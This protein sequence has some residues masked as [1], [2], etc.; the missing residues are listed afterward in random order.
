MAPRL[1]HDPFI[2]AFLKA[3]LAPVAPRRYSSDA[4]LPT[5]LKLVRE[6]ETRAARNPAWLVPATLSR[7]EKGVLMAQRRLANRPRE[8]TRYREVFYA[9]AR[10]DAFRI[11]L[12]D[13]DPRQVKPAHRPATREERM[14]LARYKHE[15]K[16][17]MAALEQLLIT[18]EDARL[19]AA[20]ALD[21]YERIS[22]QVRLTQEEAEEELAGRRRI[23]LNARTP[24]TYVAKLKELS[25]Q[26]RVARRAE[27]EARAAAS[28]LRHK[29]AR[30]RERIEV[31]RLRITGMEKF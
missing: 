16:W 14:R 12:G 26:R 9:T 30:L 25:A 29:V 3:S 15:R 24:R 6:Y 5:T 8:T 1:I 13:T 21:S 23:K 2:A 19:R 28:V 31:L 20:S 27:R 10:R 11:V 4:L 22:A 18:Y 7:L 17:R